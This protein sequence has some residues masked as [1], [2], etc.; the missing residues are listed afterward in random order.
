MK[1]VEVNK[2]KKLHW[3]NNKHT[4][5]HKKGVEALEDL[6]TSKESEAK[7]KNEDNKASAEDTIKIK[8]AIYLSTARMVKRYDVIYTN[9]KET[10][11]TEKKTEVKKKKKNAM[12]SLTILKLNEEPW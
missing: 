11:N 7:K 1:G 12:T 4:S 9:T 5:A 10:T 3:I 6:H 8:I 2:E